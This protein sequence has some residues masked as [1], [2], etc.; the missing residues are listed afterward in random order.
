MVKY[1]SIIEGTATNLRS[2]ICILLLCAFCSVSMAD[3]KTDSIKHAVRIL[4]GMDKDR[5]LSWAVSILRSAADN[6]SIAYAMNSLGMAYMAGI[7]VEQDSIQCVYWLE[8]AAANGFKEAFHN[9]GRMYKNSYCG[10][11]Q[12]FVK[13]YQYFE[14]GAEKNSVLCMYD[15]GFMLYKGLGCGQDYQ[16]AAE[17]FQ[18]ASNRDYSPALYM[19]G[20]CYRNGYGVEADTARANFCLKRSA[21]LGYRYAIEELCRPHPENYMHEDYIDNATYGNVPENMPDISP[22]VN[23]TSLLAGEYQGFVVMYDWSGSYVL[24]EKPVM[25]T[26][27]RDKDGISGITVFGNDTVP[28]RATMSKEGKLKFSEGDISLCERYYTSGKVRYRMDY[29]MFDIWQDNIKGELRLYSLWLNEPERPMYLEL[30]RKGSDMQPA[31]DRYSR[32]TISPNPFSSTFTAN[33][34]LPATAADAKVKIFDKYGALVYSR[35]L[36]NLQ[37]GKHSLPISPDI[38]Q[39]TYVLNITAGKQVLRTIIVKN[40]GM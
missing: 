17:L 5:S 37:A 39:G 8:K 10:V 9:L 30:H 32:I 35:S 15:M 25:M 3:N 33:F 18:K 20:L 22:E 36:G 27:G 12:D 19:L 1:N 31:K 2:V 14:K 23:D 21:A 34:E 29:A 28:F 26:M 24:G 40:G 6:D 7:G 16:H 38:L 13:S 4:K 11:K